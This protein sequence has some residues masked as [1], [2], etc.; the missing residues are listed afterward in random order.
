MRARHAG[1]RVMPRVIAEEPWFFQLVEADDGACVLTVTCGRSA[2]FDV[3]VT[4]TA[5]ER[6]RYVEEG[7]DVRELAYRVMDDPDGFLAREQRRRP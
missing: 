1:A 5:A 6:R 3:T 7:R 4:L 2:V